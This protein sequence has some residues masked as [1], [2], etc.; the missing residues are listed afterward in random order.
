MKAPIVYVQY[1]LD[2]IAWIEEDTK[3][4]RDVFLSSRTI[5]AAVLRYLQ[6][7]AEATQRLPEHL[8]AMHPEIDWMGIADFRNV[9]V[10]DYLGLDIERVWVT[11]E[12]DLPPLKQAVVA[13]Q[14]QIE[15]QSE[16]V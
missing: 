10:H 15:S 11:V 8:K 6:T 5:Q 1:V 4:D 14:R 7:L 3:G 2:A 13:I 16:P 9:L 12:K